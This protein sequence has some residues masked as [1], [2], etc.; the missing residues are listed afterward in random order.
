MN[1]INDMIEAGVPQETVYYFVNQP[2][3]ADYINNQRKFDSSYAF[4]FDVIQSSAKT[5][6]INIAMQTAISNVDEQDLV[7]ITQADNLRHLKDVLN[8]LYK[9][10]KESVY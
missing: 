2:F 9:K 10:D 5:K 3:I 8:N 1:V 7:T 4:I 6:A